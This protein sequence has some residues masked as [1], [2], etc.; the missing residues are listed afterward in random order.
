MSSKVL[1]GIRKEY[2]SG[3]LE[4][5]RID[6][7]PFRQFSHWMQDALDCGIEEPTAMFLATA[8]EN[9]QPSGR[10]VL[11][12]EFDESGFV[13]FTHHLSRKGV[14]MKKNP[15]VAGTFHWKE[16]ER[17][18]RFTGKVLRIS[19][20]ASEAYFNSR[21]MDSRISAIISPQSSVI[22]DRMF[23]EKKRTELISVFPG[24]RVS[25]P[26]DWGGYRIVPAEFEFWQG[27]EFRLH[28]RIC[29]TRIRGGWQI[30]R[31]AP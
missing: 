27:R 14:E 4:E 6:K 2:R 18:V 11:L 31:L 24:Q 22:P 19:R 13:F 5:G 17:Q 3:E 29:Y 26:T 15:L 30:K 21:P 25:C 7:D 20:T 1:S 9:G 16:L 23:L 12:K 10:I 28:D 8:G